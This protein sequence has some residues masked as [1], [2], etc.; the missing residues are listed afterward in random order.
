LAVRITV[1]IED[2][3]LDDLIAITGD[4]KKSPAVA[5]A[6]EDFV[7]RKKAK[8]FGVALREGAFDYHATNDEI[9][10]QDR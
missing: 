1:D 7:K 5:K 8:A 3:V 10:A 9:E 6:V 4:A 2:A